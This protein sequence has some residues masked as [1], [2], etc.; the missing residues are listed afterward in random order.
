MKIPLL[1]LAVACSL[2]AADDYVLGPDSQPHAGVP[3]GKVTKYSW[4]DSRIYPGSGRD[5]W[6]YVPAQYDGTKPACV[7]VFQD[8]SGFVSETGAWRVPVVFDNLIQQGAM[9]P[10]IAIFINP[11]VLPAASPEQGARYNRSHEYDG[12]GDRYPRFLLEEILP[13]VAKQ[14]KLSTDPNDRAVAGSSSG[15]IAAFT[16]AWERPD[17]FR[18]VLSFI[19]SFTNLQGGDVYANLIRKMEPKPLRVFLQDGSNDQNIYGGSWYLANQAMAKSLEYNGYDI[20][21]VV[22]TEGHNSKHGA[23]ILPDAL[24]WL[25]RDYPQP[26]KAGKGPKG[27]Q[28]NIAA[29]LDPDHDWEL[30]GQGYQFTEGLAVDREG[31]VYFCDAGASKIYKVGADGKPVLFKEN[32]GGA[33]GLMFGPDGRL[34][35][36]ENA[37]KRVVAYAP[38]GKI[39]VLATGVV[40]NDLAVTSK[41]DVYFTESP[42]LRV[43][44]IDSKGTRRVVFDGAKNQDMQLPNGV[45][46]TPDESLLAVSDTVLRTAW[47]FHIEA[48]GSLADGERFYHLEI[49]DDVSRGPLRSGADGVTF[50][51]Q[52]HLYVTT[53][54]GIQICDQAGRVVGII[55]N[56]GAGDPSSVVFGG[57]DLHTLY[58]T[59]GDKVYK[60]LTRRKGVFPWQP[61]KLPRPQ[62]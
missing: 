31:A 21:F 13:E 46:L 43:W 40:P 51:D 36:A 30:V 8:G 55:R 32:T 26:I 61:V 60:R 41:R 48:D 54:L 23:S 17:E 37:R 53:K 3:K 5:Y 12:L 22:G 28:R 45:R 18:R 39:S 9:P 56:P 47:S 11:G 49:P 19:G 42:A 15:G 52:G 6:V 16:V 2:G 29:F 1:V 62:L 4:N 58:A 27:D 35:A 33:T 50:D 20:Q 25:W 44:H 38:D 14:Y 34:Y 57:A 59:A 7:M 24:R 10:T